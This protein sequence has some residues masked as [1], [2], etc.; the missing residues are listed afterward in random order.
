[1]AMMKDDVM[2]IQIQTGTLGPAESGGRSVAL[3]EVKLLVARVVVRGNEE[4]YL[5]LVT[6][7]QLQILD[8]FKMR[9]PAQ[10]LKEVVFERLAKRAAGG[11]EQA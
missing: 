2:E 8:G 10:W 11:V 7:D 1:M 6:G 5:M 4:N 9:E 3:A